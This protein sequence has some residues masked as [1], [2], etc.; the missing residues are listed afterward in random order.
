[1]T[2]PKTSHQGRTTMNLTPDPSGQSPSSQSVPEPAK[3]TGT[4][5]AETG[6]PTTVPT[7]QVRQAP[8]PKAEVRLEYVI[9]ANPSSE[10]R[11]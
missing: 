11:T 5:Q 8:N 1:M 9:N 2:L 4:V 10:R 7:S 3:A 6:T